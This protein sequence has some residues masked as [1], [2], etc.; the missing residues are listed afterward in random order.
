M[1]ESVDADT[2]RDAIVQKVDRVGARAF[3]ISIRAPGRTIALLAIG[4]R[5]GAAL[6][7]IADRPKKQAPSGK[8]DAEQQRLRKALEGTRVTALRANEART[9]WRLDVRSGEGASSLSVTARGLALD[10]EA[11][12]TTSVDALEPVVDLAR[13]SAHAALVFAAEERHAFEQRRRTLIQAIS[14]AAARLARRADAVARDLAK[15]DGADELTHLGALLAAVAHT[16]PRGARAATVEDWSS[17][18][19]VER[20]LPLDPAKS[21][22]EQ[23]QG[24]FHRAK[25]LKRGRA[26]AASR[27]AETNVALAA[28]DRLKNEAENAETADA[29]EIVERR[30]ANQKIEVGASRDIGSSRSDVVEARSPYRI[31][32]SAEREIRVGRGAKDN[33]ALTTR[34]A[35]PHDLWLHAK[36]WTGAH[37]VVPLAKGASCPADLLVDAAHLAAHF[38]DARGESTV[39]VQYADRRYVR[40][41][42]GAAPGAVVVDREKVLVLRVDAETI[43][44]LL[45]SAAD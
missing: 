1:T 36:G 26:V 16:I 5:A 41:P 8:Q 45:A 24:M 12:A 28:L 2:L 3:V 29:I 34:H 40:K 19:R 32:T 14:R 30:A 42:R 9:S 31:Y 15:I 6:A 23:A 37:V 11:A 7:P 20:T 43:K 4:T 13:A 44:R 17:G 27:L 22:R 33:D 25:R 38:S 21:A 39:E 10:T 18:D 35:R